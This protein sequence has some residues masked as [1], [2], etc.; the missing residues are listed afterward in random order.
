M[1]AYVN[2]EYRYNFGKATTFQ[3]RLVS[4]AHCQKLF[5][6]CYECKI[7]CFFQGAVRVHLA[8]A[9]NGAGFKWYSFLSNRVSTSV[10]Q[11]LRYVKID[12]LQ[13]LCSAYCRSIHM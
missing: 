1:C 11:N 7:I 4:F 2:N 3:V 10:I 9:K 5:S 8:N 13:A 6:S 12:S